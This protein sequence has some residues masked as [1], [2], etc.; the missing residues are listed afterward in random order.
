MSYKVELEYFKR[1]GKYYSEGSYVTEK[2]E[3]FEIFQEVGD[4]H[5]NGRLPGLV[6]GST[7]FNVYIKVLDHPHRHPGMSMVDRIVVEA[8]ERKLR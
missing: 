3:M 8:L 2:G 1:G 6:E 4:M 5:L 7:E